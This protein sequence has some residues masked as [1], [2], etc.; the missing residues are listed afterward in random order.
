[1]TMKT[2]E[3]KYLNKIQDLFEKYKGKMEDPELNKILNEGFVS[4]LPD[5]NA[6]ILLCGINPSN[7]GK[8]DE[9]FHFHELASAPYFRTLH[10][11]VRECENKNSIDYLDLFC[12]RHTDQKVI[13]RFTKDP[14]GIKFIAEHLKLTQQIIEEIKPELIL[15]FNKTAATFFGRNAMPDAER[16]EDKNV[17]MGYKFSDINLESVLND[18]MYSVQVKSI[19]GLQECRINS[20]IQEST[21]LNSKIFFGSYMRYLKTE[22]KEELRKLIASLSKLE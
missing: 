9:N 2:F 15:V 12:F 13:W 5:L 19:A 20:E 8:E 10:D 11:I 17:W 16:I 3:E 21:I 6:K 7:N 22:K 18:N 14:V 4:S 1:M